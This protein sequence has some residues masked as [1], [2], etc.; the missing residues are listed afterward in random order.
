VWSNLDLI[1][2]SPKDIYVAKSEFQWDWANFEALYF[3]I[4]DDFAL[5]QYINLVEL[6]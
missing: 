2:K 5:G 1:V 6:W 4:H 3:L